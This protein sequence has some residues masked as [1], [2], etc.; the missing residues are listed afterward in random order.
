MHDSSPQLLVYVTLQSKPPNLHSNIH[1]IQRF[2]SPDKLNGEAGYYFTNL[3]GAIEFVQSVDANKLSIS[4]EEFDAEL[5]KAL[6]SREGAL[7][8]A[9]EPEA[10]L[11][12][13]GGAS[14]PAPAPAPSAPADGGL[15]SLIDLPSVESSS[16]PGRNDGSAAAAV[17][18]SDR[19]ST[20]HLGGPFSPG[21][22]GEL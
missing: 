8:S 10:N 13:F 11:I 19:E 22:L 12:D 4:Q 7:G 5:N 2:R 14:A 15:S 1:F 20:W 6:E 17:A 16:R 9:P 3:Q 18:P 21:V